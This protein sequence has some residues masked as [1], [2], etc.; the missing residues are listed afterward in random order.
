MM[1]KKC[2]ILGHRWL[3][4]KLNDF[5][6][7]SLVLTIFFNNNRYIKLKHAD[8]ICGLL[9]AESKLQH[10]PFQCDSRMDGFH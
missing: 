10:D 5:G 8:L 6:L 1:N 9:G 3:A 4:F 7:L 2:T